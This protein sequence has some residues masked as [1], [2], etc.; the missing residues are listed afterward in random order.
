[1]AKFTL[2]K[3]LILDVTDSPSEV[4]Q[5]LAMPPGDNAVVVQVNIMNLSGSASPTATFLH[6]GS[7]DLDNWAALASTDAKTAIGS[8][9]LTK[10]TGISAAFVRLKVTV[11]GTS[12]KV[13]ISAEASTSIQ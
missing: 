5:P 11:S 10:I 6:Q 3:G 4:S 13:V 2:F 7:N 8:S 1:M 9:F 12:A